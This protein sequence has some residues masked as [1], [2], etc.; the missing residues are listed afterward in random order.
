MT[1]RGSRA[2]SR[3]SLRSAVFSVAHFRRKVTV[4]AVK[5]TTATI[6]TLTLIETTLKFMAW[7][8]LKTALV[9]GSIAILAAGTATVSIQ[10]ITRARAGSKPFA[11]AGY[12][13]P[14]AAVQSMLWA[15][16]RGDFK[17]FE[18]ACT[19]EQIERFDNKM[20]GKSDEEI[21]RESIAWANAL[22]GYKVQWQQNLYHREAQQGT[23]DSTDRPPTDHRPTTDH[24]ASTNRKHPIR[25]FHS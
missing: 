4:A 7:T 1:T 8:K 20:A 17:T 6:S 11:F 24:K 15:G 25:H 18:T 2:G 22:I 23:L 19:P 16:S 10:H 3:A 13:T 5:G 21:K 12:S 9:V 14:E